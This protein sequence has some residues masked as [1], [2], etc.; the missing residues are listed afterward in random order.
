MYY[1]KSVWISNYS[2]LLLLHIFIAMYD[3]SISVCWYC[4]LSNN[5]NSYLHTFFRISTIENK[6]CEYND[7]SHIWR[8]RLT[9]P[10]QDQSWLIRPKNVF[11]VGGKN[12]CRVGRQGFF[13]NNGKKAFLITLILRLSCNLT[14]VFIEAPDSLS[15]GT[16]DDLKKDYF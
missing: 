14:T 11:T 5:C 1:N 9:V 12:T 15:L 8:S 13:L 4:S 7:F 2:F 10:I 16:S 6:K 3:V